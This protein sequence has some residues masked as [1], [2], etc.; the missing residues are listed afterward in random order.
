M[1]IKPPEYQLKMSLN[2]PEAEQAQD[3]LSLEEV[4]LRS[5]AARAGLENGTS[6]P[7]DPDTKQVRPP[8]MMQEYYRLCAGGWPWRVAMYIVWLAT[9]RRLRWPASQ[10]ELATQILGLT[11]D[12]VLS[13]WRTKNPVIDAL[14]RDI[15]V[16]RA[17]E[18]V[19]DS[20]DAMMEVAATPDYKGKGD[21]EL[22]LKMAGLLADGQMEVISKSG[23][24]DLSKLSWEEKLALAGL[25]TPEKIDAYKRELAGKR[26]EGEA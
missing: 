24:P 2:V 4:R 7:V 14:A 6:W 12:R 17:L 1:T 21:R 18:R 10:E 23:L 20:I 9:P 22:H 25:D 16:G 13:T 19:T 15:G 8:A 3:V 11:S 5:E 26:G